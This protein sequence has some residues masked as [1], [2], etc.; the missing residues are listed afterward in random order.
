PAPGDFLRDRGAKF[1]TPQPD[2]L[3]CNGAYVLV[4]VESECAFEYE[5]NPY[6][7]DRDR[8]SVAH[9]RIEAFRNIEASVLFERFEA[10][11]LAELYLE[12][13]QEDFLAR[14]RTRYGD[15]IFET[16]SSPVTYFL[17]FFFSLNSATD[18]AEKAIL[19]RN[20]RK[21]LFFG[22]D[23]KK[24][25][26]VR[27]DAGGMT[28]VLRNSL[29]PQGHSFDPAGNDYLDYVEKALARRNFEDFPGDF[30]SRDGRDAFYNPDKARAYMTKAREELAQ[31]GATF[32][33]T[34]I[35]PA[36]IAAPGDAAMKQQLEEQLEALFGLDT[37]DVSVAMMEPDRID[38]IL[39]RQGR[40]IENSRMPVVLP[41]VGLSPE[42]GDPSTFLNT[43]SLPKGALLA[44]MGLDH[45]EELPGSEYRAIKSV[46]RSIAETLAK[47]DAECIDVCKRLD[48]FG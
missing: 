12:S 28:A 15:T 41:F 14:V 17:P 47:A 1:G 35:I 27:M 29:C 9:V 42:Y 24:L 21:A 46:L 13:A 2:G 7:W 33:I 39:F 34:I 48:L 31:A 43:F 3:L 40:A 30:S 36:D 26:A 4:R 18:S 19:N 6:Y 20:F 22:I 5:A 38:A 25:L 37:I 32:P 45:I 23:R 10:G 44:V 11:E 8:V 16:E